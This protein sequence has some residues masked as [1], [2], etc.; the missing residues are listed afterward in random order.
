MA[1][2]REGSAPLEDKSLDVEEQIYMKSKVAWLNGAYVA[3]ERCKNKIK[4]ELYVQE[5]VKLGNLGKSM[6]SLTKESQLYKTKR[7]DIKKMSKTENKLFHDYIIDSCNEVCQICED[8]GGVDFHHPKY[9]KFG[10]DKDDTCQ[11]LVCRECHDQCHKDKHGIMNKI[12]IGVG[13][14]NFK[15][16]N[17]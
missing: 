17:G 4:T 13:N 11:I 1:G 2:E 5:N 3:E 6:I 8:R 12:A 9:G 15:A 14:M 10:A 16:Y 7:V